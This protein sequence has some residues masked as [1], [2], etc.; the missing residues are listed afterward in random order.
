MLE[1]TYKDG[2]IITVDDY[3]DAELEDGMLI[4]YKDGHIVVLINLD[5]IETVVDIGDENGGGR[6]CLTYIIEMA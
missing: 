3:D 2:R 6:K 4:F 1:V 5:C